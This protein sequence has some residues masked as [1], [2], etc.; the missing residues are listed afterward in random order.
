MHFYHFIKCA[1]PAFSVLFLP[2][3]YLLL[4]LSESYTLYDGILSTWLISTI[5][6]KHYLKA[7]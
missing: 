1:Y 7:F 3:S 6:P 2:S 5:L 4:D